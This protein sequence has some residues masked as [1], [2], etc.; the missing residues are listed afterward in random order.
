MFPPATV[1]PQTKLRISAPGDAGEAEA[2]RVADHVMRM[3]APHTEDGAPGG[4]I[5]AEDRPEP[6]G[7]PGQEGSHVE[8]VRARPSAP[9]HLGRTA[10]PPSAEAAWAP[11]GRPLDPEIRA[12]ME[13]RFGHDFGKVRVHADAEAAASA[14][15]IGALAYTIGSHVVFGAGMYAP[16]TDTGRRLLAHELAHVVQ[17]GGNPTVI[18]RMAPCPGSLSGAPPAGWQPY[19]GDSSVFHCGYRGILEDRSPTPGDPQNECFYDGSG[20]LVDETH[21]FSGCRG[22]PNQYDSAEHPLLHALIDSG[23]IVRAGLPALVETGMHAGSEW[24]GRLER[25]ILKLYGVPGF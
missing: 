5:Q 2:D 22:T 19:H 21:P 3:A 7:Q 13:P 8:T 14:R 4:R 6:S 11:P 12:F 24:V 16:T 10:T 23:G 20:R 15:S 9:G 18:Q 1:A 17:Q 25:E